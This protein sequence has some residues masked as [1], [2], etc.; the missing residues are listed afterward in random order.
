[1]Y[2]LMPSA[3]SPDFS[4][5]N[6]R[7]HSF[8]GQNLIG[9][10]FSYADIRGAD[11]TGAILTNANFSHARAG[12]RSHQAMNLTLVALLLAA[13]VGFTSTFTTVFAAYL[14]FP[15]SVSPDR[16]LASIVVLGLSIILSLVTVRYGLETALSTAMVVGV[17]LGALL[18]SMTGT[19]D[20]IAAGA[21]AVTITAVIA[22]ACIGACATTIVT[23]RITA[24]I[25][26]AM[27]A[28]AMIVLGGTIAAKIGTV[29]G[30]TVAGVITGGNVAGVRIAATQEA[31]IAA[32]VGSAAGALLSNYVSCRAATGDPKFALIW[33]RAIAFAAWGG[34]CFRGADLTDANFTQASLHSTDFRNAKPLRTNFYQVKYLDRARVGQTILADS[35]VRD[36]VVTHQG[37][38]KPYIGRNLKGTNLAGADLSGAD[39]TEVD[40]SEATLE[41]ACLEQANLTKVQA[42]GS[43]FRGTRLTGACIEA[44]NIDSTTQLENVLC[45]YIYLRNPQQERRPSS[46]T[47]AAGDFT[48]LF[49]EIIHTIDLIF[50]NGID[51]KAF[52]YSLH[53]LQIENEG[54]A[55]SI[56]SLEKKSNGVVVVRV[57]VPADVNKAQLHADFSR[58]YDLALNAIEAKYQAQ[59]QAKDEQIAFYRQQQADWKEVRQLLQSQPIHANNG[60]APANSKRAVDK[61]VVLH[62]GE[63]DFNVGF[64]VNLQ[65]SAEWQLRSMQFTKGRLAP[66]PELSLL[67]EQWRSA[68]CKSLKANYRLDIPD[69]QVTNWS[70]H[71][72]L[73]E[74]DKAAVILKQQLNCWLNSEVFRPIKERMLEQL[75][76][77][78]AIRI[79]LQ[80]DNRQLRRLPFQ[81]WEFFERYPQ[82]EIALSP[83]DCEPIKLLR[84]RSPSPVV[85]VLAILGDSRGIDLQ[86]DQ[87]LLTQLPNTEVTFLVEP[88]RQTLNDQLWQQP[89]DILFFAGHSSSQ[90][91]SDTGQLHINQRDRITITQLEHALKKAIEQGLKLAIFNSC[92][93]LGLA[94]GL[95]DLHVPQMIVMREPVPDRVAQEFLKNFLTSFSSGKLL[96]QSVREAREKLQ[97]LEDRFPCATW[98]PTICQNL[99]EPPL[100]WQHLQNG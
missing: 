31:E 17:G 91:D 63:G 54:I 26:A 30:L 72:F 69:A 20:G 47:F 62:L 34:T 52:N 51:Q 29:I 7:G 10:N 61:L 22:I 74:C 49:Q 78:E 16:V 82:A 83:R 55:L 56:R 100:V 1:M 79:V 60:Y 96:Y 32:I 28:T 27:L 14:L 25:A 19:V 46:G 43:D 77:S 24:G 21:I 11:F 50:R 40:I 6:L 15:Y 67:Y 94:C 12:L 36:L 68:Y 5:K 48:E 66:A 88:Q 33:Q 37:R 45:D 70:R 59:L 97:G 65:I 93:G 99:A 76:P 75:A 9:V 98:L 92:D 85:R 64:P 4:G 87:A 71:D 89:W 3:T 84:S 2:S 13:L 35:T 42:V 18:G 57:D 90:I 53:Q 41:G 86:Q 95:A 81:L 80:T 8:R 58:Y 39:L 44:W 38:H 73:Q 23:T